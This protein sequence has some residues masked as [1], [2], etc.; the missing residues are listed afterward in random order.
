VV[1]DGVIDA[2]ALSGLSIIP[3]SFDLSHRWELKTWDAF[4][5][6]RPFARCVVRFAEPLR[7]PRLSGDAVRAEFRAELQRRLAAITD[8]RGS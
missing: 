7:V 1:Q 5:V 3:A 8:Q 4:Q 6:P 2:A